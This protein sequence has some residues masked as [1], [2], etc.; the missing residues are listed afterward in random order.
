MHRI[1]SKIVADSKCVFVP[2][3]PPINRRSTP[4]QGLFELTP[5]EKLDYTDLGN[6][7]APLMSGTSLVVLLVQ[8][9]IQL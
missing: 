4:S 7:A 2:L 3:L 1:I 6:E 8:Q 5:A 9:C